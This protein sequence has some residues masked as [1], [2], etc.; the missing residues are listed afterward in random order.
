M[1]F[2]TVNPMDAGDGITALSPLSTI[3]DCSSLLPQ[4]NKNPVVLI[5]RKWTN[6]GRNLDRNSINK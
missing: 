2:K 3:S 5:N 6:T 1:E 4:E